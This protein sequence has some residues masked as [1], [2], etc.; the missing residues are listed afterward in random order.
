[1]RWDELFADLEAQVAAVEAAE[2]SGEIAERTRLAVGELT[3]CDRLRGA[4]GQRIRFSLAANE[5]A[6]GRLE[7]VGVDWALL[8]EPSRR[9]ALVALHQ[10]TT[11]AGL[12][13]VTGRPDTSRVGPRLDLRRCLR[14]LARDRAGA[15]VTLLDGVVSSGTIDRVGADFIELADHPQGEARRARSVHAVVG[16]PI[17]AVSVVRTL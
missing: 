15:R 8:V 10:V 3:L 6:D 7:Q 17:R 9:Q 5:V 11:V 14:Q 4:I 16:I 1:M 13:A 12:R 2:R